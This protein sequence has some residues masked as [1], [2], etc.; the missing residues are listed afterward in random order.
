MENL[1]TYLYEGIFD[2]DGNINRSP[3]TT[4]DE[5]MNSEDI[6]VRANRYLSII[7]YIMSYNPKLPDAYDWEL[8]ERKFP[9]ELHLL[10]RELK[11]I[12]S[13]FITKTVWPILYF[14]SYKVGDFY[15]T[16]SDD[17]S[18]PFDDIASDIMTEMYRSGDG[19]ARY[20]KLPNK[21]FDAFWEY[22]EYFELGV[23]MK[24]CA[25]Y[26]CFADDDYIF[27]LGLPKG[28]P[29]DILNLFNI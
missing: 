1:K 10:L 25:G 16:Y 20:N 12:Y 2:I 5:W 19:I 9:K 26:V 18:T 8:D 23:P 4:L 17:N 29:K 3:W 7:K 11:S 13:K 14:D 22:N 24:N 21:W 15:E 27:V 6:F 28:L